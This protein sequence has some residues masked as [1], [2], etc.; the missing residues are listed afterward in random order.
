MN[1]KL[2]LLRTLLR[3]TSAWNIYKNCKDKKKRGSIVGAMIGTYVLYLMLMTYCILQCVGYGKFGLTD[4][5]P[6]LCALVI[7]ILAFFLTFLKTNGYLFNFKEYDMLMSLPYQPKDIAACKFIYMYVKSLPW[8]L[9]VSLSMM[10]A[11]VYF[12]KARFVVI[13]VWIILAIFLPLIPMLGAS[14]LGFLIA[15]IGSGFRNKTLVQTVITFIIVLAAFGSRFFVEKMIRDDKVEEVVSST[16]E[17]TEKMGGFYPPAGWFSNSITELRLSDML[18]LV[19]VS[20]I[21]FAA[22]FILVGRS[23]RKINSALQSHAASK[24]FHM[25]EKHQ[26]QKSILNTIA[27]K[28]F[29]RMT[30]STTYMSNALIGQLM[31]VVA[32]IAILFVD[33]DKLI[34]KMLQGAP[35]T[36]EMLTP[37]IPLIIYFFVG[38][39]AT[40]A[41]TPSLEGKNYWIV[42]SLPISK[43][44]LYQGKMLYNM[45]LTV[46]F[47]V[48]AT[49]TF[50]I[51]VKVPFVSAVLFVILAVLLCAFSTVWGCY[52]GVKHMRLDWENEVEVIK[53]GA[54]VGLY[55]FPNMMATMGL[56]VLVVFLGTKIDPKLISLILILVVAALTAICYSAVMRFAKLRKI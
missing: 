7:S 49:I 11:Y 23:Y 27:F 32:G 15:K 31:C 35:V 2:V 55:L 20:G 10:A 21:L 24:A 19:G 25:D 48:F 5:I 50:S 45:Y 1:R 8:Y 17:A 40:T 28:E 13:P 41:F 43:K 12:A 9:S 18:L 53:Q 14:L 46:P 30:G 33:V 3:S 4:S 51:A 39:V 42:C 38:M 44:T 22:L 36:K 16:A 52:C 6:L 47:A 54:A 37:A 29:R 56:V 26:K 34:V